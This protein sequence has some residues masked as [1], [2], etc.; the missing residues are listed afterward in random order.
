[1]ELIW[2]F[3]VGLFP[4]CRMH[5][6]CWGPWAVHSRA[7]SPGDGKMKGPADGDLVPTLAPNPVF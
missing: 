3:K 5:T 4:P 1:M 2:N 6:S 7:L